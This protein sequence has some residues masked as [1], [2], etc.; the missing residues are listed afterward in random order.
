MRRMTFVLAT[1]AVLAVSVA[2]SAATPPASQFGVVAAPRIGAEYTKMAELD[3]QFQEFQKEQEARLQQQHKARL[4]FDD[5]QREFLDFAATAAPTEERDKRLAE[6]AQSSDN[7][8]R[9]LFELRQMKERTPEQEEEYQEL[10]ALYEKRMRELAAL[11]AELQKKV[12]DKRAELSKIIEDDMA[13]A[14]KAVAEEKGLALVFHKE[15]VLFGGLDITDEV[16]AK[17]NAAPW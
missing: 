12:E 15:V 16:I 7:R 2:A 11:Q 5:E 1:A 8:E 9:K 4:L 6:L 14:I 3:R 13:A 10:N 17:L